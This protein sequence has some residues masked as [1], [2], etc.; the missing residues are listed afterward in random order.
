MAGQ[1][2]GNKQDAPN[3]LRYTR[4]GMFNER[5]WGGIAF[6][7]WSAFAVRLAAPAAAISFSEMLSLLTIFTGFWY[8]FGLIDCWES[9]ER[10]LD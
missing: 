4:P 6:E 3:T 2:Q 10:I 9:L 7:S 8:S 1:E 5:R